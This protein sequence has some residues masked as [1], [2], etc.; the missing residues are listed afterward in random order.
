MKLSLIAA[1]LLIPRI[2]LAQIPGVAGPIVSNNA[3]NGVGS[4]GAVGSAG[5]VLG[6]SYPNPAFNSTSS[7]GNVMNNAFT[8]FNSAGN[9][10]GEDLLLGDGASVQTILFFDLTKNSPS[11]SDFPQASFQATAVDTTPSHGASITWFVDGQDISHKTA[12]ACY[13]TDYAGSATL[14][15]ACQINQAGGAV[16]SGTIIAN[17]QFGV[18]YSAAGTAIPAASSANNHMRACVSD[19]TACTSGTTY[20]SGGATA[21]EV[22]SNG[23]AWK[24]SGSGC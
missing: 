16:G 15:G 11:S 6:G 3:N 10:S 2:A 20:T 13:S 22:W 18:I 23:S 19:S 17:N 24:E 12:M 21:C 8:V 14:Q 9:L 1:L 5:G 7:T 4:G